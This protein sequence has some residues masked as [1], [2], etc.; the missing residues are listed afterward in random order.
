MGL[1]DEW[2]RLLDAPIKQM[3]WQR[4]AP[5][6]MPLTEA[7]YGEPSPGDLWDANPSSPARTTEIPGNPA[8]LL[9]RAMDA[10]A[11]NPWRSGDAYQ[12]AAMT[13]APQTSAP[14]MRGG[15]GE[16]QP[17]G[18]T[19]YAQ[20]PR[21]PPQ[22]LTANVLRMKGVPEAHIA[23]AFDNPEL[24]KQLINRNF[25]PGSA[26]APAR[27]GYGVDG[28]GSGGGPLGHSGQRI[29]PQIGGLDD[30]RARYA[31]PAQ[32][33]FMPSDPIGYTGGS[34]P[35][36]PS[37]TPSALSGAPQTSSDHNAA[38]L[39]LAQLAQYVPARPAL[40][41][42]RPFIPGTPANKDWTDGFIKS[43]SRAVREI[44]DWLRGIF[45]ND[46]NGD[47][48]DEIKENVIRPPAGSVPIDETP[49]SSDHGEIKEVAGVRGDHDV[50]I[51][52]KGDVWGQ[53]PDG[54]WSNYGPAKNITG[55]GR[56]RGRRGKDRDQW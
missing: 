15:A 2:G 10:F 25:G 4:P 54:T 27:I 47:E 31:A 37:G 14:A 5:L 51:S 28:S 48:N 55:S 21:S 44:A 35:H 39:A 24:M 41:I 43:N 7:A 6:P 38:G 30:D 49:W 40:P 45:H 17:A 32:S 34:N 23:A 16:D 22:N 18:S 56:P 8:S 26:G 29:D 11:A 13:P 52:P 1:L 12:P 42:P 9:G 46:E 3:P 19:G 53:H 33:G 20:P 36:A 50:R